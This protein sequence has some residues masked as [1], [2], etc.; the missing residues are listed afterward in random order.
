M[1]SPRFNGRRFWALF[2]A[3]AVIMIWGVAP[4]LVEPSLDS[5][6]FDRLPADRP[7]VIAHR[8]G[9]HLWP[10][11]TLV[12][13]LG[14]R[15][16]GVDALELDVWSSADGEPV[17]IHDETVDRTTN[18]SGPVRSFSVSQLASLD[19]GYRFEH[20]ARKGEF[21]YRGRDVRIPTLEEVFRAFPKM[22]M[23]IEI[24]EE[25]P[26]LIDRVGELIQEH[27]RADLSLVGSFCTRTISRFR[28]GY[29]EVATTAAQ[30]EVI[31]FLFLN[32]IFAG[33]AYS[34]SSNAFFV[35]T[36]VGRLPVA[37]PRFIRG[38]QSRNL[39]VGVWTINEVDTMKA[40][41][42]RGVDALITD[43]PDLALEIVGTPP[44]QEQY[45]G[46]GSS[47]M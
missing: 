40:L 16:M 44:Q 36:H 31:P 15:E 38:A 7:A 29:P 34:S 13:F 4:M 2:I 6:F 10:E 24:K 23:V 20:H 5:A 47:A 14:A 3:A 32:A 21:P 35:P 37:T 11:N 12:A 28:A 22:L 8:G 26:R 18:G 46:Q 17:V 19:A 41:I 9:K 30:R 45:D 1:K 43:R 27:G 39:Y 42:D 33:R 25:C